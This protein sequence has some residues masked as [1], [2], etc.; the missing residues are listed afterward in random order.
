M[1][2]TVKGTMKK[3]L[4]GILFFILVAAGSWLSNALPV[5]NLVRGETNT[6]VF[7]PQA[8][9]PNVWPYQS[10]NIVNNKAV[11]DIVFR[12]GSTGVV[13]SLEITFPQGTNIVNAVLME[14]SGIGPGSGSITG[15]KLTFT[16][17]SPVS[18]PSGTTIRLEIGN[19]NNPV[20]PSNSLAVQITTKDSIGN[21]IDNGVQQPTQ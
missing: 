17:T 13:K 21:L 11:Y 2:S 5:A 7:T 4:M 15:Q 18:V 19:I 10:N 8:T 16:I 3:T 9:I 6:P 12:T 14:E 1:E 20:V